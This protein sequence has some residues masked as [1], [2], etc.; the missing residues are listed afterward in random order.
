VLSLTVWVWAVESSARLECGLGAGVLR[1]E[2]RFSL[3]S[4][5]GLGTGVD[6]GAAAPE[7]SGLSVVPSCSGGSHIGPCGAWPQGRCVAF[8]LY[9]FSQLPL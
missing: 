2:L 7:L 1:L 9:G 8:G 4:V 5:C 3:A 6:V